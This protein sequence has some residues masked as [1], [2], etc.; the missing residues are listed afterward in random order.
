MLQSILC[1]NLCIYIQIVKLITIHIFFLNKVYVIFFSLLK[2]FTFFIQANLT[3][4]KSIKHLHVHTINR[5]FKLQ[6]LI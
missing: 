4:F 1:M 3:N 6:G 2:L 5:C